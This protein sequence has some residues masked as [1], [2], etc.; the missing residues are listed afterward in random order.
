[1]RKGNV[2]LIELLR[3]LHRRRLMLNIQLYRAL[4]TRNLHIVAW[5]ALERRILISL[6]RIKIRLLPFLGVR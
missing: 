5:N 2:L 1:M 4:V 3:L 6:E